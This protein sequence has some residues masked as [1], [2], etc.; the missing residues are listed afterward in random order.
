M[1]GQD[2]CPGGVGFHVSS[3]KLVA[4]QNILCP[5]PGLEQV[6]RRAV[7]VCR[8]AGSF[9]TG[10]GCNCLAGQTGGTEQRCGRGATSPYKLGRIKF[11]LEIQEVCPVAQSS[12]FLRL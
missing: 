7:S 9:L 5:D 11:K 6:R 2:S 4:S 1:S 8:K 12:Y 10:Q 3:E